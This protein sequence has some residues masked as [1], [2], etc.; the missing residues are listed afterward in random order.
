MGVLLCGFKWKHPVIDLKDSCRRSLRKNKASHAWYTTVDCFDYA[1]A[2]QVHCSWLQ[3]WQFSFHCWSWRFFQ[4]YGVFT[5]DPVF[6]LCICPVTVLPFRLGHM[7]YCPL[8]AH[9][10]PRV[11]QQQ[12]YH[13]QTIKRNSTQAD[14]Y[15]G[16]FAPTICSGEKKNWRN[17][18][19]RGHCPKEIKKSNPQQK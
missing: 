6:H 14:M 18:H 4:R 8:R 15:A 7:I 1:V 10:L 16:P 9:Y 2:L 13:P 5:H 12:R 19:Q 17:Y 3:N 11:L